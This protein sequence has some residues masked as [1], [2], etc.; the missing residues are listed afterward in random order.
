MRL[1]KLKVSSA[2]SITT[3]AL[4]GENSVV[5]QAGNCCENIWRFKVKTD[6]AHCLAILAN[7]LRLVE[8]GMADTRRVYDERGLNRAFNILNKTKW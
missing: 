2:D 8:L 6:L 7:Q 1:T 5:L 4:K 3:A